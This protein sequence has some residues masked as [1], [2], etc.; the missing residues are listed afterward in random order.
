MQAL[1]KI[2]LAKVPVW[3]FLVDHTVAKYPC[4]VPI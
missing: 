3:G 1:M 2:N 4:P